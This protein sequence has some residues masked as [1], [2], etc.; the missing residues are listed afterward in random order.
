MSIP[1]FCGNCILN[2]GAWTMLETLSMAPM[3]KDR[4]FIML[5]F[6]FKIFGVE[7]FKKLSFL[8][9]I[10]SLTRKGI[11]YHFTTLTTDLEASGGPYLCGE[12]YT[13][14]DIS[15]VPIFERMEVARWWT[16][17]MKVMT[18]LG[19]I[20]RCDLIC[21]LHNVSNA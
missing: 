10:L 16:D 2:F 4:K 12:Q 14:A 15:M 18:T 20:F 9:K 21:S 13:L 1:A 17:S 19:S 8:D 7:T 11:N 3:V 6:C 5:F